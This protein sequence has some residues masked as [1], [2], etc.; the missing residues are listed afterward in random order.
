MIVSVSSANLRSG[1]GVNYSILGSAAR[2]E[3]F[4]IVARSNDSSWYLV[5]NVGRSM[6]ISASVVEASKPNSE[7]QIAATIPSA[8]ANIAVNADKALASGSRPKDLND[9]Q[10][11][12][13]ANSFTTILRL[14]TPTGFPSPNNM[15]TV[16]GGTYVEV[17]RMLQLGGPAYYGNNS[18]VTVEVQLLCGSPA[19]PVVL[20]NT[21]VVRECKKSECVWK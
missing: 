4:K 19:F 12:C 1:P 3:R 16:S 17:L 13:I 14:N 5:N 8:P 9:Y 21:T 10:Y 7:I 18:I 6:W 11:N 20:A 2:G 15:S